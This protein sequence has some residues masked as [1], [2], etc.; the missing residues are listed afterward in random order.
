MWSYKHNLNSKRQLKCIFFVLCTDGSNLLC[1]VLNEEIMISK[2]YGFCLVSII[3]QT[4]QMYVKVSYFSCAKKSR[5]KQWP[6]KCVVKSQLFPKIPNFLQGRKEIFQ[7]YPVQAK[8]LSR[9]TLDCWFNT[10][11]SLAIRDGP[12]GNHIP[13]WT[14]VLVF[15][16]LYLLSSMYHQHD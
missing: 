14:H 12:Y 5:T 1:T 15:N 2:C 6:H 3:N 11:N 7:P 13:R 9:P 16:V 4:K 8:H 10:S